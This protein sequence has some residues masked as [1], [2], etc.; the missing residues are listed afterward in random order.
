MKKAIRI[1]LKVSFVFYLFALIV[2]LFLDSRVSGHGMPFVGYLRFSV[3]LIPFKTI[4]TY[5]KAIF[6]GRMNMGIP[7]R[8]L[9]GNLVLFLP[10][11]I[12]LPV[13]IKKMKSLKTYS[14]FMLCILLSVEA[15]QLITR[16]GSFDIDDFI[17]NMVGAIAGFKIYQKIAKVIGGIF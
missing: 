7:I 3:N 5:I 1:I 9:G 2:V 13:L 6:D 12:Y 15:M 11:G 16:R 17:L 10:M 8:N 14:I 4:G